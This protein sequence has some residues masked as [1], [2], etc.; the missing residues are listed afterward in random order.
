MRLQTNLNRHFKPLILRF[1]FGLI[2]PVMVTG[3]I[4]VYFYFSCLKDRIF[5]SCWT[6]RISIYIFIYLSF[7]S[8]S[9]F[10]TLRRGEKFTDTHW[11]CGTPWRTDSTVENDRLPPGRRLSA[12]PG[13]CARTHMHVY[14]SIMQECVIYSCIIH[15][16]IM[17][18]LL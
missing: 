16:F 3:I 1:E 11:H 2:S 5:S 6:H 12:A 9:D 8:L 18:V 4:M 15:V 10:F 13:E 14:R 7:F 17:E